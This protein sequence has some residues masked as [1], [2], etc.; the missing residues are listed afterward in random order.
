MNVVT[1]IASRNLWRS[2]KRSLTIMVAVS[3]GLWSGIFLIAFYNGMIEERIN[4]AISS[5]ISHIQLHNNEFRK[6]NDLK[7]T[8]P[9]GSKIMQQIS[10]DNSVKAITGRI[11]I[12]GMIG[13]ASGSSGITIN[14]I[15]PNQEKIITNLPKK[16]I[17][18]FYF[19]SK[20]SNE[21]II[22][23]KNAK[24]LKINLKKKVVLT[25]QD[26]NGNLASS[27][28]RVCGIYKTINA[29][30]DDANVFVKINDIDSIAG[31]PK[32]INE[33]AIVLNTNNS[34]DEFQKKIQTNFPKIEVKN[35]KEIA[36]ELGLTVTVGNQMA[37]IFM[38][39][40]LFAL[41]FGIINTMMMS[42]LERTREI[43]MLLALGMNRSKIFSMILIETFLL[44]LVGCP[45]GI[46]LAFITIG[47]TNK[48]GINFSK[49]S[50]VYSSFGYNPIIYP[51]LT[52]KQF[53][54]IML[55]I[56]FTALFSAIFPARKALKINP[57]E[58]LKK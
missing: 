9:N 47:I 53:G 5:E 14:S 34:L 41:A 45:F 29:P 58:S 37:Y 25:F 13:S 12:K 19:N 56:V 22:S 54:I 35:W 8:L 18:G 32:E 16:I 3:I 15:E 11:I 20:K 28:F 26:I 48:T 10:S 44:V 30:Y 55:L 36:P 40:I 17:E 27:A 49:F 52:L 38:G 7:F 57:A 31:I 50:E 33:I 46:L 43:G 1:K 23:A 24:K 42:I 21:I 4:N 6:E 2:K 51:S 39:I